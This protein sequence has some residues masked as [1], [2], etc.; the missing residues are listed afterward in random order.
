MRTIA[1]VGKNFGD[2]GKG[3][4]VDYFSS[5]SKNTMVVRHNGGAQSGHTV[6]LKNRTFSGDKSE[7]GFSDSGSKLN[8]VISE[9]SSCEA[10]KDRNYHAGK[11]FVF[12]ELSS[13]SLRHA[14]TLWTESFYPDL[15]KLSE[16]ISDFIDK[17]GFAPTIY[18]MENT[19]ITFPDDVLINMIAESSRGDDR[20]GSCGMGINECDLRIAA[21]YGVTLGEISR[22]N[23]QELFRRLSEIREVYSEKRVDVILGLSGGK[24]PESCMKPENSESEKSNFSTPAEDAPVRKKTI[25]YTAAGSELKDETEG[26]LELLRNDN[27]L[28]NA[29]EV[30]IENIKYIK[31]ITV[32][33]L[34]NILKDVDTLIF[35]TGQGLLLDR[36]NEYYTPHVTASDTG[37]KNPCEFLERLGLSLHEAVYVS[38]TYVTRHGAGKLHHECDKD[39]LGDIQHDRTNEPNIWQGN[40]RYGSHGD[41]KDFVEAVKKDIDTYGNKALKVSLFLTHLNETENCVIMNNRKMPIKEFSA[42]PE[43]EEG[44][45]RIYI[46]DSRYSEDVRILQDLK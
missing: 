25:G 37:I 5:Y 3:L 40:I 30:I 8:S 39:K 36:N 18:A 46:S 10:Q 23:V 21:G 28:F 33:E 44:F 4:A 15:Y 11:R 41:E 45:D 12:H 43:I 19:K 35:E 26:Y 32:P 24:G 1:V 7:G 14:G 17:F 13:G 31:I 20:H 2:E 38:R 27:V 42:L 16:E 22:M 29:A 6:E 34:E 9:E